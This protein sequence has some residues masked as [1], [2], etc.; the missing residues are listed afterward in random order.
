MAF[1]SDIELVLGPENPT[2]SDRDWR[3]GVLGPESDFFG[4]T[5]S[6]RLFRIGIGMLGEE[7]RLLVEVF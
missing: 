4:S 2:I 3:I 5:F 1:G 7:L 6:D